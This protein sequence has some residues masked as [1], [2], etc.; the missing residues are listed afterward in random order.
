MPVCLVEHKMTP[1]ELCVIVDLDDTIRNLKKKLR[2]LRHRS[3]IVLGARGT[4]TG[5]ITVR[6]LEFAEDD[7]LVSDWYKAPPYTIMADEPISKA[8]QKLNEHKNH[9]LIVVDD[10]KKPVGILWDYDAILGC[11]EDM[12]D[13][14]SPAKKN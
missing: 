5:V 11:D 4:V 9:Q 8:R 14:E 12:N 13:E 10:R 6:D 7:D 3:A 1:A 2:R